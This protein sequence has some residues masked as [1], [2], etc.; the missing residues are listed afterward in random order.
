MNARLGKRNRTSDADVQRVLADIETLVPRESLEQTCEQVLAEIRRV[1]P[2]RRIAVAWSGGKDSL[3]LGHLLQRAGLP[4]VGVLGLTAELEYPA[5]DAWYAT[6]TPPDITIVRRPQHTW[7]WLASHPAMLFPQNAL[8]ADRW[9]TSVWQAAQNAYCERQGKDLLIL[10]RRKLDENYCGPGTTGLYTVRGVTRYLPIRF[11]TH[12]QILAYLHYYH[13]TLPP[14]YHWF[15]GF[16]EG[17]HP[18]P[19]RLAVLNETD[20]W[21]QTF[22][23]DPSLVEQAAPFF[24]GACA[25]LQNPTP[26]QSQ[27]MHVWSGH[28]LHQKAASSTNKKRG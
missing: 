14:V 17:T 21:A 18:W 23:A 2:G 28:R 5:M 27:D 11:W 4:L 10:G 9:R 20:G 13:L 8:D 16:K 6:H 7:A 12:E 19:M 26:I 3:V 22:A 1:A 24:P 15:N 25:Y